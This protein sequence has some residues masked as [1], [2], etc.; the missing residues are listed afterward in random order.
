MLRNLVTR[1]IH[2]CRSQIRNETLLIDNI[3]SCSKFY[4]VQQPGAFPLVPNV[5]FHSTRD[6]WIHQYI[7]RYIFHILSFLPRRLFKHSRIL[8]IIRYMFQFCFNSSIYKI[9]LCILTSFAGT[10]CLFLHVLHALSWC[11][12]DTV[13]SIPIHTLGITFLDIFEIYFHLHLI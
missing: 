11:P 4:I 1:V 7:Y 6:S 5:G 2:V 9:C 3:F 13:F 10:S 8:E 12:S